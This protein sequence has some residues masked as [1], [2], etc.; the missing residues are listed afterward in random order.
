MRVSNPEM[1]LA[2]VENGFMSLPWERWQKLMGPRVLR[3]VEQMRREALRD[4]SR[5]RDERASG[6]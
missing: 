2:I 5:R 1:R 3:N 6:A 4:G